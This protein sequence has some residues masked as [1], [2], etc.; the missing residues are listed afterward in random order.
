CL[1]LAGF[2]LLFG[3]SSKGSSN[4]NENAEGE[5][6]DYVSILGASD[7]GTFFLLANGM[8]DLFNDEMSSGDYSAQSTSGTND[9]LQQLDEG[10]GE[11]GFAQAS[12]AG[13]AVE[14][15][16]YFEDNVQDNVVG[17][18]YMYPNVMHLV[19]N[20]KTGIVEPKELRGKKVGVGEPGGGVEVDSKRL[21]NAL[22]IDID[23]DIK[24][25]HVTGAQGSDMLRNNQ[26]D[27]LIMPGGLGAS[28]TL[29]ILSNKNFEVI[30]I[31]EEIIDDL[32]EINPAYLEFEIPADTYPN[33]SEAIQTYAEANWLYARKD[34][35]E[36][37]VYDIM[38]TLYS[39]QERM[40]DVHDSVENMTLENSQKGKMT[41]LH[42]GA[43]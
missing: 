21:L 34:L 5:T 18:S 4:N 35:S 27:A 10:E 26:L 33:Q 40:I 14:G 22:D 16:G 1:F 2:S 13:D 11:L 19:V 32:I 7:G 43:K 29:E 8:A 9:I 25:E 24:A 31:P 42:P 41:P 15:E 36:D 38:K 3:C 39:N 20:K 12:M 37:F 17:L 30:P 23:D 6:P 28:N